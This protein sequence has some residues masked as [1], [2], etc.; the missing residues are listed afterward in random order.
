MEETN[1]NNQ[2][3]VQNAFEQAYNSYKTDK[4]PYERIK[5][6]EYKIQEERPIEEEQEQFEHNITFNVQSSEEFNKDLIIE[7]EEI[8][9]EP[10]KKKQKINLQEEDVQENVKKQNSFKNDPIA[11]P[12]PLTPEILKNEDLANLLLSWYYSGYY[13]GYYQASRKL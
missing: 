12:P 10:K 6:T 3:I 8:N 9:E 11:P 1:N 5:I 7:E 2:E 13:T 4:E